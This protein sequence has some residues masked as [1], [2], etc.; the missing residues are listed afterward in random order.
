MESFQGVGR[1]IF[2]QH[3]LSL[4]TMTLI[5]DGVIVSGEKLSP[6]SLLVESILRLLKR[7]QIRALVYNVNIGNLKNSQDYAQK[8]QRNCTF[9]NLAGGGG[10]AMKNCFYVLPIPVKLEN[11]CGSASK[12]KNSASV[13][14]C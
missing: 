4:V 1:K 2:V 5:I 13:V 14:A 8:P 9:M 6:V 7:L 10:G 12:Q 11:C 3:L